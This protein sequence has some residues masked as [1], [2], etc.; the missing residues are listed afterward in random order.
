MKSRPSPLPLVEVKDLSI[1]RGERRILHGINWVIQPGE[2]W[3]ILG[4]NGSGKT[5][6]LAAL[7]G[8]LF[9]TSGEIRV[10]GEIFGE[11]DWR[12]LRC[13]VGIVSSS[14]QN[15]IEDSER[16]LEMVTSGKKAI[17]NSWKA[18]TSA[19]RKEALEILKLV[20]CQ[21]LSKQPWSV[22]SQ[23]ERQRV[24]IGRALMA[25][26]KIL[27]LDEPCAGLDPVA[28]ENFLQFIE[29]LSKTA[30]PPAILFVTHHLEEIVPAFS[31]ILML[32]SGKLLASG[33]VKS[34]I[35]STLLT[36]LFGSPITV[37][38]TG[39][40]YMLSVTPKNGVIV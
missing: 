38:K 13:H 34:C 9:P 11:S 24:L 22:L 25:H 18:P 16:T 32:R 31:Q 36:Q 10:L 27:I 6:L 4:P 7:T 14:I 28:R 29:R 5:S 21:H 15:Q 39:P 37:K 17:I 12:N 26:P 1:Y 3:V 30:H 2:H 23:G 19:E 33:S 8:Y 35:T 20:E 40:K